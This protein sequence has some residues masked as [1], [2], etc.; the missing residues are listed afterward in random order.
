MGLELMSQGKSWAKFALTGES[1]YII[2]PFQLKPQSA[3]LK[4]I[5]NSASTE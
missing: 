5:I 2:C 1:I 4:I 3:V